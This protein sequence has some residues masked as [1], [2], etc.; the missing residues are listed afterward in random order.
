MYDEIVKKKNLIQRLWNWRGLKGRL[1]H[2]VALTNLL[3]QK[4]VTESGFA[5]KV[6]PAEKKQ[7]LPLQFRYG[8]GR[9]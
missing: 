3:L 8:D 4:M 1:A 9:F 5:S 2:S 7:K 6:F